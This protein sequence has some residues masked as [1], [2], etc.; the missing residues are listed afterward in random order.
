MVAAKIKLENKVG[1]LTPDQPVLTGILLKQNRYWMKQERR[2]EL[3]M[4]GHLKYYKNKDLKGTLTLTKGSKALKVGR[5]EA[6]LR[7]EGAKKDYILFSKDSCPP[8]T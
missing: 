5:S 3:Y 8:K 7:I 6:I 1:N 4:N 2:F